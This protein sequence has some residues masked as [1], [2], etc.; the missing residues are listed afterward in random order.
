[1]SPLNLSSP[2]VSHPLFCPLPLGWIKRIFF[3]STLINRSDTVNH[4]LSFSITY[5]SQMNYYIQFYPYLDIIVIKTN[6]LQTGLYGEDTTPIYE[7]KTNPTFL[8]FL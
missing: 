7:E 3:L 2:V 8:Y 6:S 1:M 5:D 4:H